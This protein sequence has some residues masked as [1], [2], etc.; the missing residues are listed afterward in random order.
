MFDISNTN[1]TQKGG[2]LLMCV[3]HTDADA[4]KGD[5]D[6]LQTVYQ[7]RRITS[8]LSYNSSILGIVGI[9]GQGKTLLIKAK[10]M[11]ISK[12]DKGTVLLPK[13]AVM[14]D[15]LDSNIRIT[16]R[17]KKF[18][19]S[20]TNWLLLWKCAITITILRCSDIPN[21]FEKA[22]EE[23]HTF[24]ESTINLL[25]SQNDDNRPCVIVYRI[26]SMDTK[27]INNLFA[28][29]PKLTYALSLIHQSVCIFI[30]KI[31]QAFSHEMYI[32]D[33]DS[34]SAIGVRNPSI[35]QYCQLALANAAY[36]FYSSINKHI[37]VY[38]TIRQEALHNAA[39]IAQNCYRNLRSYIVILEYTKNDLYKMYKM[40]IDKEQNN[41]LI[42]P[43]KKET[44]P[45]EAFMGIESLKHGYVDSKEDLFDYIYRH[46]MFRPYD[47][48][49]ICLELYNAGF[50][51]P[52]PE[53]VKHIIN[54]RAREILDEYIAE[55]LPFAAGIDKVLDKL[56]SGISTNIFDLQYMKKVCHRY[57]LTNGM[58][59]NCKMLCT[60]CDSLFPFAKMLNAGLVGYLHKNQGNTDFEQ[61][62]IDV[63][64]RV[65]DSNTINVETTD[66]Y[67]LHPCISDRTKE[68]R[69]ERRRSYCNSD[70]VII[71]NG[72]DCTESQYNNITANSSEAINVICDESTFI[73]STMKEIG[74][75]RDAAAHALSL[76]G[77]YPVYCETPSYHIDIYTFSHDGCIDEAL[78][79]NNAVI[80][81]GTE[82]GGEYNGDKYINEYNEIIKLSNGIIQKPSITLMEYYIIRKYK[83]SFLT[84][85]SQS[86]DDYSRT[87]EY[88]KEKLSE[89]INKG[90]MC[91]QVSILNFNNK[92]ILDGYEKPVGNMVKFYRSTNNIEEIISAHAFE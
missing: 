10:R 40:Y 77:Y 52:E 32:I 34:K 88:K 43:A 4:I 19:S 72:Y 45:S 76:K 6:Q 30:D 90:E 82:Y 18:L 12:K 28:D 26:I 65:L 64:E 1:I 31:D 80:I 61:R 87:D 50:T 29:L 27:S 57:M 9:K 54:C 67:F 36:D 89:W 75:E 39:N 92:L 56:L 62:F 14:V 46:S 58:D 83:K 35:W 5:C 63:S 17:Q 21:L 22:E 33:G 53:S 8:F 66:I 81:F 49:S 70:I 44:N 73:S 68:L 55:I 13:D 47:I 41:N 25:K 15:T 51:R 2:T 11:L 42:M 79:C 7:N 3:W 20:Y 86:I 91:K 24:C 48:V 78:K 59:D 23:I 71:G 16:Q 84:L 74:E 60:T 37:K 69:D 85:F 38:F